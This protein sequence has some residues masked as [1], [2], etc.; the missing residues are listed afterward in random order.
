MTG[1]LSLAHIGWAVESIEDAIKDLS[2]LGFS[3]TCGVCIDEARK[4]KLALVS[5]SRSNTIELVAPMA[6]DSP[7]SEILK[8]NGPTPYHICF[9]AEVEHDFSECKKEFMS[10]GFAVLH[11]PAPA[12]LFGGKDVVFLYS[13]NLG[14]IELVIE[15]S[16]GKDASNH[17]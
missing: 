6:E 4:V 14:L 10:K 15:P 5:D 13:K 7:V 1:S 2:V 11:K 9:T 3:P 12:P 8:K 17:D 16:D